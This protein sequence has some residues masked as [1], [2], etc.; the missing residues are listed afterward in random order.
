MAR[1]FD[2]EEAGAVRSLVERAV[3]DWEGVTT[4]TVFG[5][6][7]FRV[8]GEL[9]A[10]VVTGGVVP[11]NLEET[12]REELADEFGAAP[13]HADDRVVDSW[14]VVTLHDPDHFDLLVPY[15]RRSYRNAGRIPDAV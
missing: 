1:Y 13:F 7:A 6:P 8:D 15:L 4:A 12:D 9:F 3:G 5:C 2:P 14:P 10:V 11:T